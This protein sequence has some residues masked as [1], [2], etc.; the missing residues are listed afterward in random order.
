LINRN[1][2]DTTITLVNQSLYPL[3]LPSIDPN[4]QETT[5]TQLAS[6]AVLVPANGSVTLTIGI[7][8]AG[9]AATSDAKLTASAQGIQ[10]TI[11][12]TAENPVASEVGLWSG[13]VTLNKVSEPNGANPTTPTVTPAEFSMRL[14]LHFDN[15][16][17]TRLL[18]EV[19]V[20]KQPNPPGSNDTTAG[21][22]V[23]LSDSS[24]VPL[25]EAPMHRDGAPFSPR[26]SAVGYDFTGTHVV[27]NG[28]FGSSLTGTVTMPRSHPNNPF[29][30]RYHPDHDD[31]TEPPTYGTPPA[32]L[33][34]E[35]QEVWDV[36]RALEITFDAIPNDKAPSS[37]FSQRTGTYKETVTGLHKNSIVTTGTFT[38][39]RLNTLGELNP[40]P[41][42]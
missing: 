26:V 29:K 27:L 25:F 30:H 12:V 38:L 6:K 33:P 9:L 4:T 35:K 16:G 14:L 1:A 15:A 37:G 42:P 2:T 20:M 36:T 10:R 40:A 31:L 22:F 17:T 5:W 8:R 24:K 3:V 28:T 39:Q 7:H 41:A 11:V 21:A 32:N 19:Y 34:I 18:K 13:T 23:L